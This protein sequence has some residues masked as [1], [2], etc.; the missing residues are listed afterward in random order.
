MKSKKSQ[1]AHGFNINKSVLLVNAPNLDT[2]KNKRLICQRSEAS[3]VNLFASCTIP[4][5]SL[6]YN[7]L[8]QA[9]LHNGKVGPH[10]APQNKRGVCF[11]ST[12]SEDCWQSDNSLLLKTPHGCSHS[13]GEESRGGSMLRSKRGPGRAGLASGTLTVSVSKMTDDEESQSL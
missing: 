3:S 6:I 7:H 2:K 5:I 11:T 9:R 4:F 13:F 1:I 12:F 10:G 8:F